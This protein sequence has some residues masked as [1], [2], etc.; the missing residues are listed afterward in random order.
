M[1]R[2]GSGAHARPMMNH[3]EM[4]RALVETHQRELEREAASRR[5]ARILRR[6]QRTS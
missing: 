4:M 6:K 1:R 3:H 5:L 2:P